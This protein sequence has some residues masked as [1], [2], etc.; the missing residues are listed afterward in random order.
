[1]WRFCA[2]VLYIIYIIYN[3]SFIIYQTTTKYIHRYYGQLLLFTIFTFYVLFTKTG[4]TKKSIFT[5]DY[6]YK[7]QPEILFSLGLIICFFI[8]S[9]T[10]MYQYLYPDG[11]LSWI[12]ISLTTGFISFPSVVD[13]LIYHFYLKCNDKTDETSNTTNNTLI[14]TAECNSVITHS[15]NINELKARR[16]INNYANINQFI[17]DEICKIIQQKFTFKPSFLSEFENAYIDIEYDKDDICDLFELNSFMNQL[18][19]NHVGYEKLNDDELAA[20]IFAVHFGVLDEYG[21]ATTEHDKLLA[22]KQFCNILT[23]AFDQ[24]CQQRREMN[25]DKVEEE[26]LFYQITDCYQNKPRFQTHSLWRESADIIAEKSHGTLMES[27]FDGQLAN[28]AIK[29][30]KIDWKFELQQ[31]NANDDDIFRVEEEEDR[32]ID[33]EC[34]NI[35]MLEPFR[36]NVRRKRVITHMIGYSEPYSNLT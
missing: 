13:V 21:P 31:N 24:I 30:I 3:I 11:K 15:I 18:K 23:T 9:L 20:I 35:W 27:H 2:Y 36:F 6:Y 5:L 33:Y 29:C 25:V 28:K 34:R 1:M 14:K 12:V 8:P 32:F 22:C 7:L 4:I 10:R 19:H 17:P 16:F 26:N